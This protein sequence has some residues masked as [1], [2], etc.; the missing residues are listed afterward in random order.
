M[1]IFPFKLDTFQKTAIETIK[2]NEHVLVTAH[3]GSGKTVPAEF[4]IHHF[5]NQDKKV[6]YTSPIKSLSN[7]KFHELSKR[8]PNI[9]FGISTGDIKF[10]PE[11]DCVIMTTEILRNM[12]YQK[13]LPDI[14]CVIFDE[15]HYINDIHRGK[16]WEEC[17]MMLPKHVVM[18]M[19]SATIQHPLLFTSWIQDIK[20]VSVTLSGTTKRVVPLTH[21]SFLSVSEFNKKDVPEALHKYTNTLLPI[22]LPNQSYQERYIDKIN[23]I[24]KKNIHI[25]PSFAINDIIRHLHEKEMLPAICFV[26]SRKKAEGYAQMIDLNLHEDPKKTTTVHKECESILR[27]TLSNYNEYTS[28]SEYISMMKL[29][30]KG[31]AVHHSGITPVI[32]E[33]IELL[34]S[35]GYIKLLFATETFSVGIN[36]PTKTVLFT[37]IT[38]WDGVQ[39]RI[40]YAHEYTQMAGRAGRRG[41][42]KV[43]HVI[44]L[45]S[46][47]DPPL[48]G[49]YN[50]MLS[51]KAQTIQSRLD[52]DFGYILR[53]LKN[54]NDI[55]K[56]IKNSM[57]FRNIKKEIEQLKIELDDSLQ[58]K[59]TYN[60]KTLPMALLKEYN[61]IVYLTSN[62]Y[63][64]RGHKKKYEKQMI[65]IQEEIGGSFEDYYE[66]FNKYEECNRKI[67]D[68]HKKID[69][70]NN[71]IDTQVQLLLGILKQFGYMELENNILTKKGII[72]SSIQEC[73]RFIL[74]ECILERNIHCLDTH[75]MILFLSCFVNVRVPEGQALMKYNGTNETLR[76]CLS[77]IERTCETYYNMEIYQIGY[78]DEE[79]YYYQY[80]LI[81]AMNMWIHATNE[82]ETKRVLEYLEQYGI[83]PGEFVKAILK[84]NAIAL[85]LENVCDVINDIHLK[86]IL[87]TIPDKTLKYIATNQS[88]YI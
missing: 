64:K 12:L 28:S 16:V 81:E 85:E 4:A 20:G 11:A 42:D 41:L 17:I 70:Q 78:I 27:A 77:F 60:I 82:R 47:F 57:M 73:N 8:F 54:K 59:Q 75:H 22:K 26:F 45:H 58:Q 30:E 66:T 87:H 50:I 9:E 29:L 67:E 55:V 35:K 79:E 53:I 18:V 80:D 72:A 34:F 40:L 6:I 39:Q 5:C 76:Q 33:M 44:H 3:T 43:G 56:Q 1:S 52:V 68:I 86:E 19:L 25:K 61:D 36:M 37:S 38:K 2:R 88:L 21:Y 83:F 48:H 49:D 84:I 14:A 65:N 51:G 13:E 63:L 7:Q 74:A 32:R 69:R 31:I 71:Y 24:K 15:V 62:H 23:R 10:N 46:L